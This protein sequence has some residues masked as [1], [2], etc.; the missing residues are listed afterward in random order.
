MRSRVI[1]F[2]FTLFILIA[3]GMIFHSKSLQENIARTSGLT[4]AKLYSDAITIF[5]SL[6]TSEVIQVAS[7]HGID[8]THDYHNKSALPLPVTFSMLIG[9]KISKSGTGASSYLYSPFPFPWRQ[10]TG[11]LNDDFRQKAWA[12]ISK[13]PDKPF[14]E[15][16]REDDNHFLRYAVADRMRAECISCHNSHPDTPKSDWVLNDVRGILEVTIPLEQT[17]STSHNDL[18]FTIVI[19]CTLAI[20][21]ILGIV[22]MLTKHSSEA[23]E[24][25]QAIALRTSQLEDEKTK[26]I[27]ANQAKTDFL[28][29]MSH[30]LRT[31]LNTILGFAQLLKLD[32]KNNDEKEN[33]QEILDAGNHLLLLINE[34]LDLSKIEAGH[35]DINITKVDVDQVVDDSLK[36]FKLVAN[37]QEINIHRQTTSGH[38]VYADYT[39]L[40]QVIVNLISNAIKYNH[41]GGHIEIKVVTESSSKTRI[42]VSDTGIGLNEEQQQKLFMPFERVGAEY[43]GIDGAGIGLAI[44]KQLINAMDGKIEV[45]STP[46][47]GS[48]FWIELNSV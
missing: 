8:I 2:I 9:E 29:R 4:N 38:L 17:D 28:S 24:L 18:V 42:C 43:S 11:G 34:I 10:E 21:G 40:K 39:R 47:E 1:I 7:D 12:E 20:L 22:F 31:P 27:K 48:S 23:D 36:L 3:V 41:K 46:N 35:L 5:R 26:A 45:T 25:K 30:E 16:F 33:C 6:Y 13:Q 44:C 32:A 15:F 14:F 37:T 19:Y